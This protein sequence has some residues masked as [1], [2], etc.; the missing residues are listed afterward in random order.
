MVFLQ[1]EEGR[2][3]SDPWR[4]QGKKINCRVIYAVSAA[5]VLQ[6]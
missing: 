4:H 1:L 3:V 6:F 2:V 5:L